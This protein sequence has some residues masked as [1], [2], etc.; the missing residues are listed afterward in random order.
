MI[1]SLLFLVKARV[2]WIAAARCLAT[3]LGSRL[4]L[5]A[6]FFVARFSRAVDSIGPE[7]SYPCR[8]C[9]ELVTADSVAAGLDLFRQSCSAI[10]IVAD[11]ADSVRRHSAARL[12][13]VAAAVAGA[14]LAFVLDAVS[15]ARSSF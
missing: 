2:D 4:A 9:F 1:C 7:S 15:T 6:D 13:S 8:I 5:I 11:L 3:E 14:A 12:F 10:V